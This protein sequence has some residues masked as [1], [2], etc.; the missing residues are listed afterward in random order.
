MRTSDFDFVLPSDRIAQV[1]TETR[2]RSK[3]L[4]VNRSSGTFTHHRFADV[5]DLIP[6]GDAI[7]L[8]TTRVFRARLLG[9]RD[10]GAPAEVFLLRATGE[11]RQFEALVHP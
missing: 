7:V 1:P 8:N 11:P 10:S 4:V 5:V 3:L 9:Q 2:D 6:P